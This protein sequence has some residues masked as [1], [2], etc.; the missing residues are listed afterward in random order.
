MTGALLVIGHG[1]RDPQGVAEFL[2]L[3]RMLA[4][5]RGSLP[6]GIAF[7]EFARPTIQ[8]AVE[9]L[10]NAGARRIICQPGM[11]F[12]SGHVKKDLPRELDT[13]SLRWPN[14]DFVLSDALNVHDKLLELCRKRWDEAVADRPRCALDDTLLLVVG[15]GSS[16][17]EANVSFG[18][19]V[20][21]LRDTYSVRQARACYS[22][23]TSPLLS[24]ALE[25]AVQS[26]FRRI[27]VQPYFLFTGVL[28]KQIH[29]TIASTARR[30]TNKEILSTHH[31]GV[32]P[33]LA[34]V[35][36]ECATRNILIQRYRERSRLP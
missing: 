12:A 3:G 6:T 14:T 9:T 11:L 4:E 17:P 19:V 31:L 27:V 8:E 2:Q 33:L 1:S 23:V 36:E 5:R 22:G 32:H 18:L 35:F 29:G 34:D 16:D 15:R 10:V 21:R 26:D 24:D 28:V 7:L 25:A 13:V 20:D 30:Y